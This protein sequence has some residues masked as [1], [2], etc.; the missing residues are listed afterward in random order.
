MEQQEEHEHQNATN[1][2]TNELFDKN[3]HI[4]DLV[5]DILRKKWW[6]ELV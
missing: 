2:N 6:L 3:C 4:P 1:T 5:Q